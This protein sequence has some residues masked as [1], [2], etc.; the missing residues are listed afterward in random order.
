MHTNVTAILY[1][2]TYSY[3]WAYPRTFPRKY[4]VLL[5]FSSLRMTISMMHG[6][7]TGLTL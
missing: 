5:P 6:E 7:N 3:V 4:P 2:Y 1:A